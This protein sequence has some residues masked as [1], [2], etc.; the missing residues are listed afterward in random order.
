V[1]RRLFGAAAL[2]AA[3]LATL[4][5]L[6]RAADSA[7]RPSVIGLQ[8]VGDTAWQPVDEFFVRWGVDPMGR[9]TEPIVATRY[10]IYSGSQVASQGA[11]QGDPGALGRLHV[12]RDN[13]A[14][15]Y[16]I[17][18]WFQTPD[19]YGPTAAVPLRVDDVPPGPPRLTPPAGWLGPDDPAEVTVEPPLAVPISGLT[20]Y[21]VSISRAGP[22]PPCPGET[23]CR[24][25]ELDLGSQG[26]SI[27][28][29]TLPEGV[30]TVAVCAV[31]G[32][33]VRSPMATTTL[34]IDGS[35]PEVALASVPDGWSSRPVTLTAL[36]TD[37][38]AGMAVAG[39]EGPFT[40]IA[41]DGGLPKR[42]SGSTVA[43]VVAG[44][45]VHTVAFWGRD[46]EGNSG[47]PGV[48]LAPPGTA[49]VRIDGTD[50]EVSFARAQD[51]ADPERIEATVADSLS[52]P[53]PARGSI[54]VRA[55]GEDRAFEPL[56]TTVTGS[57]LS[58]RWSSDDYPR[59]RYEFRAT[60]FDRAG[61]SAIAAT[62]SDGSA[63]V[64]RAPLKA[65]VALE[66]GFGG[67]K[68]VWQR[69]ARHDGVRR[70]HRQVLESFARR[71]AARTLAAG[72][73][74]TVGGRLLSAA[75]APLRGRKV[76]VV[77]TFD[78]GS[79]DHRRRTVLRT[80]PDG[81]FLTHLGAGPS[82]RIGVSFAGDRLLSRQS[83]R[84]LRLAVRTGVGLRV[85]T[86]R[87]TIGGAPVV[88]SGQI[89]HPGA[90]IPHA[91]LP[92]ELQFRLPGRPWEEFRTLQSDPAGGFHFAYSF[93]DDDSAGVRFLFRAETPPSGGWPFLPG[94]SRPL[95]VT[96]E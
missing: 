36:A 63:M 66:F 35:R 57:H 53:D 10:K 5:G 49:T 76:T 87:A 51:P 18:V 40:A 12:P 77:E 69:C 42:A 1:S 86:S 68:L 32:S 41:V 84:A 81:S 55:A 19:G 4:P 25:A 13:P 75:G 78:D 60:G 16:S 93:T 50:P 71:P 22:V 27:S 28:F 29:G 43:T 83:G 94:T 72:H 6:A 24:Q 88:F 61:N 62:R 30:Y 91:G 34:R 47:E 39:P 80:D 23:L 17:A 92:V 15:T 44:D 7:G 11:V 31:S 2:A 65:P 79:R 45:G 37:P 89:A 26:G 52:G 9:Q 64:L 73:G 46:A 95:P 38:L 56:P 48:S 21:A 82:R 14:A 8:V 58:A 33:D 96:G 54:A 90:P 74:V 59:G 3:L 85:S 20:G 67:R 70:C